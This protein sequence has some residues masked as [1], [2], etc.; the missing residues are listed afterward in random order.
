MPANH[1]HLIAACLAM[2]LLTAVVGLTMLRARVR[3]MRSKRL[4]AQRIATSV[5]MSA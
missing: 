3:E 5:Q 4:D 1:L 2:A